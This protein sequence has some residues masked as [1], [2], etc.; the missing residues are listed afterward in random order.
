MSDGVLALDQGTT[1]SKALLIDPTTLEVLASAARPLKVTSPRPG[2]VEQDASLVWDS[3]RE[4]ATEALAKRPDVRLN[5]VAISN[6]R[7]SVLAWDPATGVPIGPLV[8]WQDQRGVDLCRTLSTPDNVALVGRRTG[9]ELNA[10]YSAAKLRWLVDEARGRAGIRFGTVDAWLL[11]RLTNGQTYAIEA[12]NASRTL[13]FDIATLAWDPELCD[14]FGVPEAALP[15]VRRSCGP[16]GTTL[17]VPGIPDG[18]PILAVLGD[19]HAALFGHWALAPSYPAA[20]K[21]TYGTGSSVM[22]P[23]H[24]ATDRRPGVSTT[25]AWLLDEP[26]WAYEANIL[27]SGAGMDWLGTSLGVHGGRGLSELA[28]GTTDSAGAVFVPALNGLGAPWWEPDA[29]GTLTG[30]TVR[31]QRAHL[32]RAGLESVA[33][34]I[35]DVLDTVDPHQ[36]LTL[37]HV[38]GGATASALLMQLQANLLGRELL[39][40]RVADISPLGAG[41]LAARGLGIRPAPMVAEPARFVPDPAFSPKRRHDERLRW[42]QAL[43][44]AGVTAASTTSP[45]HR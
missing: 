42:R 32:A 34:Q 19:S 37:L 11:D 17:G 22:V 26:Q 7:E 16:W 12:G 30:L 36:K 23:A 39:V 28:A 27:Y 13:L 5:G 6:Q 8:S 38:G 33:H 41:A 1:S 10:M 45:T 25:L 43:T 21:A 44:R 14:L 20:G 3:I 4:A 9:L 24:R 35:C 40:A 2:W 31:T 29:V 18:V 15:E